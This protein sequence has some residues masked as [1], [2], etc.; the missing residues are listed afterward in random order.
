MLTPF[1]FHRSIRRSLFVALMVV[2]LSA[3]LLPTA[4]FAAA[5]TAPGRYHVVQ[6]G[7]NLSTIAS[8]NGL[9]LW[10]VMAANGITNPN[11]ILAGQVIYLPATGY[12]PPGGPPFGGPGPGP[13]H[14]PVGGQYY[15][16]QA[17]DTLSGIAF[18][19]GT[20]VWNLARLNGIANPNYIYSG[21]V[22]RLW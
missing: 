17:G 11:Y 7:D 3:T 2:A 22:L 6:P 13:M 15:R 4:A 21:T 19:H 14:P 1:G 12:Y 18:A 8:A 9:S 5:P 16:V 20:T 10:A